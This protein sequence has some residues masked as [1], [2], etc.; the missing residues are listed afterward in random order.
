VRL[1]YGLTASIALLM[2][3]RFWRK[4]IAACAFAAIVFAWLTL[5]N[6]LEVHEAAGEALAPF[7]PTRAGSSLRPQDW[8]ELSFLLISGAAFAAA[9]YFTLRR[10]RWTDAPV[11]LVLA[12][13]PA[14]GVFGVG[15]D[16]LHSALSKTPLF[17]QAGAFVEDLGEL[18]MLCLAWALAFG[19]PPEGARGGSA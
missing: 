13:V 4:R 2:A 9:L 10:S 14:A 1:E 17:S 19:I 12:C 16:F 6:S 5:E 15:V 8:G 11:Y 7:F 18:L 3:A